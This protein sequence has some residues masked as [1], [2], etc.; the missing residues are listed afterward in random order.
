[1][2]K[3]NWCKQFGLGLVLTMTL[4][5][6]ALASFPGE[7]GDIVYS[8]SINPD[9]YSNEINA[10]IVRLSPNGTSTVVGLGRRPMI[11]P[12]GRQVVFDRA[13]DPV[14]PRHVF[15]MNIDGSNVVDLGEGRAASWSPDGLE[16]AFYNYGSFGAKGIYIVPLNGGQPKLLSGTS[17]DELRLGVDRISWSPMGDKIV[18]STDL[19][20]YVI[21]VSDGS[22]TIIPTNPPMYLTDASWFPDGQSLVVFGSDLDLH[23][24]NADGSNFRP[25]TPGQ[26]PLDPQNIYVWPVISPDG[27]S[28]GMRSSF[29]G[30]F[31]AKISLTEP[32]HRIDRRGER[33]DWG[34]RP[35]TAMRTTLTSGQWSAASPLPGAQPD[36][37][38]SLSAI[39]VMPDGGALSGTLQQVLT[40]GSDG[41]LYHRALGTQGVWLPPTLVPGGGGS[42]RGI[43]PHRVAIA[44]AA[45]GSAQ[46]V[47]VNKLDNLVYHSMRFAN[48]TWSGFNLLNGYNG[49]ANFAARDVAIAIGGSSSSSPGTAQV[50]ASGLAGGAVFHRVRLPDGSWTP[51]DL[52]PGVI[53]STDQL[54]I[55]TALN[56]DAYVL[57]AG[58]DK[59]I[60]RQLRRADG[61]WDSWISMANVPTALRDVSLTIGRNTM[62]QH[63]AKVS[64]VA[65]DGTVSFQQRENAS[66][67]LAWTDPAI[68]PV[69]LMTDGRSA[70][71][72]NTATGA[73]LVVVQAQ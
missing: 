38:N 11:S 2:E 62:G 70:S 3:N 4:W 1:M 40:V 30:L 71:I 8:Q 55:A 29:V 17:G 32:L 20:T 49:S 23:V 36:D 5:N 19:D 9:P 26:P 14:S 37:Y 51:F 58:P 44:G 46:V 56:G 66:R 48:G 15:V 61:S 59:G 22:A 57:A 27:L 12:N 63:V 73:A 25:L 33:M 42:S 68:Q 65:P 18:A 35:M 50:I 64:Y 6:A 60:V 24:L 41:R 34:R 72:S 13:T 67:Q 54:A 21:N 10:N 53:S 69:N 7:N 47:I 52:P 16:V 28:F 43:Y 31:D 45:D 39:T